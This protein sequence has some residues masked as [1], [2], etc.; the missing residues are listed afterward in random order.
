[1]NIKDFLS[2]DNILVDVRASDKA[3]LLNELARRAASA[4]KLPADTVANEIEKRDELG[5]TGIGGGVSIPHA[6]LRE[7]KQPFGLL[8]RLKV[9][10]QVPFESDL[11]KVLSLLLEAAGKPARILREPAP[12]A[13]ILDF[14]D[15]RAE[16]E[17]RFWICDAQ[18]GIRNV[19]GEVRLEIWRLFRAHGL[20]LSA[21][22]QEISISSFPGAPAREAATRQAASA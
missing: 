21:P 15:G 9:P 7:V 18:N 20:S 5:S 4:L 13:L 12:R 1:M 8:A 14:R 11:D 2:A 19:S 10:I 6:R 17:L 16:L 3:G 22:R